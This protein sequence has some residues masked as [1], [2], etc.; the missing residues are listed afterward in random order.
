MIILL[1]FNK[2]D[3]QTL[4]KKLTTSTIKIRMEYVLE[5]K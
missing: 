3:D 5:K 2:T 4:N 1:F